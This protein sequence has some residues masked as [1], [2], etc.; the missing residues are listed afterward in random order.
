MSKIIIVGGGAAGMMAAIA[1]AETL[2]EKD[3]YRPGDVVLLEQNEKLGKK[4]FITGKGR[5]NVTNACDVND[6]FTNIFKNSK[7]LYSAIY[8]FDNYQTMN[9]F[10]SEGLRL[11]TE[12]GERVFPLSDHSSDVIK[13]LENKLRR[14]EVEIH[15]NTKV[16]DI[17]ITDDKIS[18]VIL[19]NKKKLTAQSVVLATGG[20]SYPVTGSTGDGIKWSKACGHKITDLTPGLVP[21]VCKEEYVKQLQGLSLKNVRLTIC[22]EK[23]KLYSDEGEMLFTHFGI[24]GPLVLSAS[25]VVCDRIG[26]KSLGATIDL[27]MAL[28]QEQLD[29]RILRDF[30]KNINKNFSNAISELLPS[31]MIPVIIALSKIDPYK[32]VHE[33]TKEERQRF[34]KLLKEFPLTITGLRGF[35]EAIITRGGVSVK[36]IN[37]STMES[38]VIAGLYFAGEMIDVDAKTGGFNLQ[39]AWSTGHLAGQSAGEGM[40]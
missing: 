21:F 33:I 15:L 13:T 32:K 39:I 3:D 30:E 2:I 28:D 19:E 25:S 26:E 35:N 20:V 36:D 10:E 23:K 27:K 6:L 14:L 8:G 9:F 16:S 22:D 5:C 18:G 12:R 17:Q 31:K 11:K 29:K 7:F 40:F 24:S 34:I 1:A 38:K 4:V 37:P